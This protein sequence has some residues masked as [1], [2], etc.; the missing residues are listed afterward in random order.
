MMFIFCKCLLFMSDVGKPLK[1]HKYVI[2]ILAGGE[3]DSSSKGILGVS[4]NPSAFLIMV[5][6]SVYDTIHVHN[7]IIMILEW[8]A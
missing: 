6:T 5:C 4:R 1:M 8:I 3:S 2:L 7:L